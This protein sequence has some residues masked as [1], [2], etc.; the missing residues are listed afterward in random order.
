[1]A[2]RVFSRLVTVLLVGGVFDS[3]CGFKAF[4]GQLASLVFPLLTVEDFAF[5]V[6]LYYVLLKFNVTIKRIP[7]RLSGSHASS[8]SLWRHAPR[9]VWSVLGLPVKWRTARYHCPELVGFDEDVY[10]A[11]D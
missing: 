5:D 10:W 11:R 4:S 2:S 7:V 3:Q 9:M 6:E 1:V 8:V